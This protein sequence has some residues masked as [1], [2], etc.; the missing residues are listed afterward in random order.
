MGNVLKVVSFAALFFVASV[1]FVSAGKVEVIPVSGTVIS[2]FNVDI[3]VTSDKGTLGGEVVLK[4]IGDAKV[5]A[6]NGGDFACVPEYTE[7]ES[8]YTVK[9]KIADET[10]P[11]KGT[12]R[13]ANLRLDSSA[14]G[15]VQIE[16]VST[17]LGSEE[18]TLSGSNYNV[19]K[20]SVLDNSD[21][22]SAKD[23]KNV[24]S[25]TLLFVAISVLAVVAV[26]FVVIYYSK[27]SGS[28][29]EN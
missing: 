28:G 15:G 23:V 10:K 6:V 14:T 26:A 27:V 25:G 18:Y 2:P 17:D 8:V 29:G 4:I 24:D 9:C 13:F 20:P 12:G 21:V 5:V 11:F 7:S 22:L 16:V 1:S 3:L 19:V